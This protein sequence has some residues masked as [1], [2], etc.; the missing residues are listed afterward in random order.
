MA[1]QTL[2]GTVNR[3]DT[4]E[5]TSWADLAGPGF[6]IETTETCTILVQ[7]FS[8]ARLSDEEGSLHMRATVDGR[9]VLPGAMQF[10]GTTNT[11]LSYSGVRYSVRPGSHSVA[12]QWK[13]T[14]GTAWLSRRIN[15]VWVIPE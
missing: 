15:T 14:R 1:T 13:V 10:S 3:T 2:S 7:F 4:T 11:T 5:S 8:F 9:A 12:I 6:E